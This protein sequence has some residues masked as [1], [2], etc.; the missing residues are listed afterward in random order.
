[1]LWNQLRWSLSA[2]LVFLSW[3]NLG[4]LLRGLFGLICLF[5]V[6]GREKTEAL[7]LLPEATV[8]GEILFIVGLNRHFSTAQLHLVGVPPRSVLRS[9]QELRLRLIDLNLDRLL[10]HQL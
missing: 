4:R 10:A 8:P 7:L 3:M 2:L 6:L 5:L 9:I 1:M